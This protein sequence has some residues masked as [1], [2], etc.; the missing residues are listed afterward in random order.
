[1]RLHLPLCSVQEWGGREKKKNEQEGEAAV[2]ESGGEQGGDFCSTLVRQIEKNMKIRAEGLFL[3]E[4][5]GGKSGTYTVRALDF[6]GNPTLAEEIS[7]LL[8]KY[9]FPFFLIRC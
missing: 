1:M 9:F 3:Y 4:I 7:T 6:A 2:C 5:R 8:Y